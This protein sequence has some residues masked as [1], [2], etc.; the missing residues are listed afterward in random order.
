MVYRKRPSAE[1]HMPS[2][3]R[4]SNSAPVL[5]TSVSDPSL[6]FT[7]N[8]RNAT[9]SAYAKPG[10]LGVPADIGIPASRPRIRTQTGSGQR[11][12]G[13]RDKF[14]TGRFLSHNICLLRPHHAVVST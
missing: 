10:S 2:L 12:S 13:E 11:R 4:S 1:T 14:A 3:F 7:V 8:T 6:M 9:A 5:L